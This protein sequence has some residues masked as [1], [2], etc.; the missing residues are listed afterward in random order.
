MSGVVAPFWTQSTRGSL[1][2][3]GA[4]TSALEIL[5]STIRA[6]ISVFLLLGFPLIPFISLSSSLGLP[7]L[8]SSS[9]PPP[10]RFLSLS[11]SPLTSPRQQGCRHLYQNFTRARG[12]V[13]H[14][15]ETITLPQ[16]SPRPY[17]MD[18]TRRERGWGLNAGDEQ[19]LHVI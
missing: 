6:W 9:T 18:L 14:H 19:L 10:S 12:P 15:N 7:P 16:A 1:A 11:L 8:L 2:A 17:Y 3:K 5:P 4:R 13:G